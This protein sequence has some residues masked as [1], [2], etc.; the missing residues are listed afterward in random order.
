[1]RIRDFIDIYRL[2]HATI[3]LKY[4]KTVENDP[5][6]GI[7]AKRYYDEAM[8]RHSK[9]LLFR[10]FTYGYAL[11]QLPATFD[12]YFNALESQAR[13]NYRKACRLGYEFRR[14]DFN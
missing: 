13:G 5:F 7:L 6:Y 2:P 1:M 14:I 9:W 3:N 11:C 4:E 10:N 8:S 12:G